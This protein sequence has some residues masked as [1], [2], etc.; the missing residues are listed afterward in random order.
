[1][2]YWQVT[3]LKKILSY[4]FWAAVAAA[5]LFA[6]LC[7]FP[8]FNISD[9]QVNGIESLNE[10]QVKQ[11][12]ALDKQHNLFA[13]NTVKA[14]NLM[15]ANNYVRDV[16]FKKV[17]PHT[18]VIDVDEYKVRGYIPYM[19]S[20]LYIDGEGRVLDSRPETT[21]QLP[22]VTGLSFDTF[23]IGQVLN[24]NNPNAY[25]A[26]KK[27][28]ALFENYDMLS[29]VIKMDVS[30]TDNIRLYVNKVTVKFGGFND[31]NDKIVVLNEILKEM[32]TSVAGVLDMTAKTPTFK[33][34]S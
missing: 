33:Y 28:A 8:Y 26:V 32:D 17:F 15:R 6:A 20:Y 34:L 24:T 5:L 19:N 29:A 25:D 12:C 31:A 23:T 3:V 22:I 9:V 16:K 21:K 30:D 27:M 10:E 2:V 1:M 18:L 11:I 4:I 7:L 13:Y 14:G